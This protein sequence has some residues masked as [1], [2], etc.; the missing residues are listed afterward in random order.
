M[1]SPVETRRTRVP[2]LLDVATILTGWVVIAV[3]PTVRF[4]SFTFDDH[5]EPVGDPF[6][7]TIPR[8]AAVAAIAIALLRIASARL[9]PT[10]SSRLARRVHLVCQIASGTAAAA[11]AVAALAFRSAA[12]CVACCESRCPPVLEYSPLIIAL[13]LCLVAL[14]SARFFCRERAGAPRIVSPGSAGKAA[15]APS[16]LDVSLLA[17]GI[18]AA[19]DAAPHAL[20]LRPSPDR[21]G[22]TY[23]VIA[24]AT[25][26]VAIR[27][28][29]PKREVNQAQSLPVAWLA[30]RHPPP[31][32]P[33]H[34]LPRWT[35]FVLVTSSA[36]A[37]WLFCAP[38]GEVHG[39][40][41]NEYGQNYGGYEDGDFEP[42]LFLYASI[43]TLTAIRVA[44][45]RRGNRLAAHAPPP[46]PPGPR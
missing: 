28:L 11:A 36:A 34:R 40:F 22:A 44:L 21:A 41:T 16:L 39:A 15:P 35:T 5:G 1:K 6:D 43:A 23:E 38:A 12:M 31:E 3:V 46:S 9:R 2:Y 30:T 25:I 17:A 26:A 29:F 13:Y 27:F 37:L 24:L 32:T 14:Q 18:F 8:V 7:N 45:T 33:T 20:S 10:T 42:S 19:L 4:T